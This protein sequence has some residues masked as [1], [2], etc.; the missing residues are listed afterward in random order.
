MDEHQRQF[1]EFALQHR[2]LRFGEF[3]LK[4]GR[5]SPYFFNAGLFNHGAALARLGQ[6][7]AR[8]IAGS[9]I[10]YDM[11]F[12]P[13]YKGIT[14]AAST[15][16]ALAE[17][18]GRDVAFAFN[19]KEAKDHSEGGRT[20]GAPLAG[21]V[22]ILDDVISAG[23]SVDESVLLIREADAV[24]AGVVIALDRGERGSGRLSAIEEIGERYGIGVASIINIDMLLEYL[25]SLPAMQG[26]LASVQSYRESYGA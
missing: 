24:P 11:L 15:A 19:R 13:A 25:R 14:L 12:G 6:Y 18:H 8:T 26:H 9:G 16:I 20:L 7:Y 1:I 22:L 3:V 10:A 2:V 17:Q 5:R 23:T 4:S 21:A